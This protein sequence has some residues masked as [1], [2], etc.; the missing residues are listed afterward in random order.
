MSFQSVVVIVGSL[1][2]T[3]QEIVIY[4]K[5]RMDF[6][7][8]TTTLNVKQEKSKEQSAKKSW[9]LP[10]RTARVKQNPFLYHEQASKA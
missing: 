2:R 9:S 7:Y 1:H 10:E 8:Y 3:K 6:C 4:C 5:K